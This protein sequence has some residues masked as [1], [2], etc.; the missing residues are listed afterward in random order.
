MSKF[1]EIQKQY[2][3]LRDAEDAYW[4]KL[5]TARE[6]VRTGFADY[7]GVAA[8]EKVGLSGEP[9]IWF[10]G[11]LNFSGKSGH[12]TERESN[13]L[14]FTLN[15]ILDRAD[16][17]FPPNTLKFRCRLKYAAENFMIHLVDS[18]KSYFTAKSDFTP[19]Y[20][21][22]YAEGQKRLSVFV[23]PFSVD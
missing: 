3:S 22:M 12:E 18:E 20:E 16:R 4:E 15:L 10:G 17:S 11:K 8:D 7:L 9:R 23:Q 14:V 2:I 13:E 5:D 19:F 21:Y 6:T 1:D